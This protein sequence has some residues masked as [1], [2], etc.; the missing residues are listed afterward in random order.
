MSNK[1]LLFSLTKDDFIVQTFHA[2]GPGGQNQNKVASG[3]RIIHK[4]SGASAESRESRSQ[5]ENKR[6]A[7]KKLSTNPKFKIWLNNKVWEIINQKSI[8]G[9]VDEMMQPDNLKV[10]ILVD[11]KW[12]K[13]DIAKQA[14]R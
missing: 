8:E 3:V 13:D 7:L 6:I 10:E 12:V 9:T 11:N 4:E 14:E 1:E 2:G 5:L